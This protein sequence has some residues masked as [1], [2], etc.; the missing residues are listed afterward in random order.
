MIKIN[1]PT[2]FF[3]VHLFFHSTFCEHLLW[4]PRLPCSGHQTLARWWGSLCTT[5]QAAEFLFLTTLYHK[6]RWVCSLVTRKMQRLWI[7]FVFALFYLNPRSSSS[8]SSWG[9]YRPPGRR[10]CPGGSSRGG[11]SARSWWGSGTRSLS[12]E[13]ILLEEE[14]LLHMLWG[15]EGDSVEGRG[16]MM[17]RDG[18]GGGLVDSSGPEDS[19]GLTGGSGTWWLVWQEQKVIWWCQ[20]LVWWKS[21]VDWTT[22]IP[23]MADGAEGMQGQLS[24]AVGMRLSAN[25]MRVRRIWEGGLGRWNVLLWKNLS[26]FCIRGNIDKLINFS[27]SIF[28]ELPCYILTMWGMVL[29]EMIFHATYPAL[30]GYPSPGQCWYVLFVDCLRT[31]IASVGTHGWPRWDIFCISANSCCCNCCWDKTRPYTTLNAH[32]QDISDNWDLAPPCAT[33]NCIINK[34]SKNCGVAI[35]HVAHFKDIQTSEDYILTLLSKN[36]DA[37]KIDILT[38]QYFEYYS[39]SPKKF[40]V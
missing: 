20:V 14:Q 24:L 28:W 35:S 4:N 1:S 38:W 23:P 22:S 11:R 27:V 8:R 32:F 17:G 19:P 16:S 25:Q 3:S 12:G 31:V 21:G 30:K 6:A 36:M 33:L 13:R 2:L 10:C 26:V 29:S 34:E 5:W 9:R 18:V 15:V 7:V 40:D 37:F 39:E